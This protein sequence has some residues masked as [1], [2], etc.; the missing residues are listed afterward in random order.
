[1]MTAARET[2]RSW[3]Y[4]PWF[5]GLLAAAVSAT[6]LMT[7]SLFVAMHQVEQNESLEMNAQG[8]RFLARLEQLFGQLRESLDDLEAQPLRAC[9]YEMIATLQQVSFNYRFVYEAAYMDDSRICSN[10]PRQEGLSLIR[11]PDIQGPTY[12]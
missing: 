10:R 4:R 2:F 3:F 11:A 6:L 9:D 7:G 12:S 5:L 1:M 8:E